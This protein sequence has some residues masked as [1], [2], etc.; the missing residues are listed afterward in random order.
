MGLGNPGPKY[1]GTRHN[2]G[3]EVVDELSRR[4]GLSFESSPTDALMAR[5]RGPAAQV[6]LAKPLT[7]MNL[8]GQA[9]A[10]LARYFRIAPVDMLVVVD[11]INLPLGRIRARAEGSDGGHNGL[12]SVIESLGTR[13]FPRL[14]LGVG[15]GDERRNLASHVLAGFE[16]DERPQV[17]GLVE[18]A[19]DAAQ[20]FVEE[21][22]TT[23]MNRFNASVSDEPSATS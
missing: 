11:D 13:S 16:P 8:S 19:A 5:Q 3:F 1:D 18:R 10:A 14:R 6:M 17:A 15:R 12:R 21:G 20:V 2:I 23:V 7:F 22:I 4:Y 9:V